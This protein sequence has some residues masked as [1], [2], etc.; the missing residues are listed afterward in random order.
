MEKRKWS[1]QEKLRI[2]LEGLSLAPFEPI[3]EV[4]EKFLT[5]KTIFL[6]AS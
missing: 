6:L 4:S 1:T 5:L 3:E 2:V